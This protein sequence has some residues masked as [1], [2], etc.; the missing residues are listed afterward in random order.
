MTRTSLRL[1]LL[2]L[3]SRASGA[4]ASACSLRSSYSAVSVPSPPGGRGG[5]SWP[6]RLGPKRPRDSE[7]GGG[8]AGQSGVPGVP[9]VPG[10]RAP[11]LAWV[12]LSLRRPDKQPGSA[13]PRAADWALGQARRRRRG[14]RRSLW[15]EE[16]VT[17]Q[18]SSRCPS[19][20]RAAN[21]GAQRLSLR[22]P[23]TAP[24]RPVAGA[25]AP[26]SASTL[27]HPSTPG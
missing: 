26:S 13:G 10:R 15:P 18:G 20:G 22:R 23:G 3:Q 14:E 27:R 2:L 4:R 25:G 8:R 7:V 16:A 17:A 9:P 19:S 21:V 12:A 24:D 1:R 6:R 5:E 11:R